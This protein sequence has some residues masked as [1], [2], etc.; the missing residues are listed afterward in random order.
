MNIAGINLQMTLD[1]NR[2]II[3]RGEECRLIQKSSPIAC[4]IFFSLSIRCEVNHVNIIHFFYTLISEKH[5]F[6][7]FSQMPPPSWISLN[8]P[9]SHLIKVPII[10]YMHPIPRFQLSYFTRSIS[11]SLKL[12]PSFTPKPMNPPFLNLDDK[13]YKA[14]QTPIPTHTSKPSLTQSAVPFPPHPE[15]PNQVPSATSKK[16]APTSSPGSKIKP[17]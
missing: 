1:I 5:A 10:F 14:I 16:S 6:F 4:L 17:D 7:S 13:T 11:P 8:I 9:R 3:L 2:Q 15:C 12:D